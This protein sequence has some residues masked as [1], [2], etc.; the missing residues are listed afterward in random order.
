MSKYQQLD[1]I[2]NSWWDSL[3]EEMQNELNK[4]YAN[5]KNVS[6]TLTKVK[7]WLQN[8]VE[9]TELN[10]E[11]LCE[12]NDDFIHYGRQECADGLL[13]QIKKWEDNNDTLSEQ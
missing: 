6:D 5:P 2:V 7:E 9:N 11:K 10:D 12:S 3:P 8:E 13:T 1:S 4:F